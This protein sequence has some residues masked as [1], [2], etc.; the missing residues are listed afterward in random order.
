MLLGTRTIRSA[1]RTSGSIEITLPGGLHALTGVACRVVLRD[2]PRPEIVLQP[3]LSTVAR[4]LASLWE[5]VRLGLGADEGSEGFTLAD[6]TLALRPPRYWKDHPPLAYVD[7]LTAMQEREEGRQGESLALAR[8]ISGLAAAVGRNLGLDTPLALP[9][10]EAVS[11]LMTGAA[12][13]V[14]ADFERAVT[15]GPAHGEGNRSPGRGSLSD[16]GTWLAA[17]PALIGIYERFR[18]WQENPAAYRAARDNWYRALR[19]EMLPA[20]M[21]GGRGRERRA[22][23]ER[24]ESAR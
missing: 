10:G 9:F 2:G 11:A 20:T 18:E 24:R 21:P 3:E 8:V 15:L 19:V 1:G 22:R 7:V 4:Y 13:G 5:K 12:A 14:G 17:R 16:R 23:A 6:F